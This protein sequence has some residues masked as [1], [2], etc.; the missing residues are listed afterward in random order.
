MPPRISSAVLFFLQ[1][2]PLLC[3]MIDAPR[4]DGDW[5][6]RALDCVMAMEDAFIAIADQL[7]AA[8]L[9]PE[10]TRLA[11]FRLRRRWLRNI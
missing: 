5:P 7:L 6:D 8:V 1:N 11:S 10:E 3:A 4:H 2:S 9:S